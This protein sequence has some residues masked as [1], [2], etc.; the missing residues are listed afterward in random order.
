MGLFCIAVFV[1]AYL[2]L[3]AEEF[4]HPRKSKPVIIAAGIAWV[5]MAR[6]DYSFL[7]GL[8]MAAPIQMLGPNVIT[9]CEVWKFGDA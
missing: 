3:M 7:F 8:T 2:L 4:T 1:I 9:I 6:S 5:I